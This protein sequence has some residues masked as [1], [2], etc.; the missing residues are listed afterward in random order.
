MDEPLRTNQRLWDA[1]TKI[2]VPS[3]FYDVPSFRDGTRPIR[4]ADY[5]RDE[6]GSVEGRTLLHL[7]CHF[8]LDT[9]SWA[10]LGATVTGVDFSRE[11]IAAARALADEVGVAARFIESDVYALPGVLDEQFDVVY[12]S[13]GVLG[14]LPDIER[15][16][17]VAAQFVKP[18]GFLYVTEIH[19]VAQVFEDEGVEPGELRL[20]YPYWTNAEPLRFEVQG[21]YADPAA[22]TDGL[23]E[24]GW[25]HSLGEIV[26]SLATAGLRIEFL[27]EL[28]FVRWPVGFLVEGDDGN[29]RLP[30]GTPGGLP[31]FFSLKA[32]KPV[33]G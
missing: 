30:P 4:V 11:A 22:P 18:G 24:Y 1:W 23:V 13:C 21:S 12:T 20:R 28:D 29:W 33:D 9:L 10:R 5:E 14:W 8:G 27:H 15:W 16:G 31:L 7:Q 3:A 26:T 19:P 32:S 17:R 2:H 25:D 6:V